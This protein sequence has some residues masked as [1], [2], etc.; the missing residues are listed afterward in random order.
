[1]KT[2]RSDLHQAKILQISHPMT[3]KFSADI[4]RLILQVS[5]S[6]FSNLNMRKLSSLPFG[7]FDKR[8]YVPSTG[9]LLIYT[10]K[11]SSAAY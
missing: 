7:C 8:H 3:F 11:P 6:I 9:L 5:I 4:L 10:G 2:C 1:M